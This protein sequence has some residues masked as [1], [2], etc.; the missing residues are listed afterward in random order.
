MVMKQGGPGMAAAAGLQA[1]HHIEAS[2]C[3]TVLLWVPAPAPHSLPR[4]LLDCHL[5]P[6]VVFWGNIGDQQIYVTANYHT[7]LQ[8]CRTDSPLQYLNLQSNVHKTGSTCP[9]RYK[10]VQESQGAVVRLQRMQ[11][12]VSRLAFDRQRV[13]Q[14]SAAHTRAAAVQI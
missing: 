4:P 13:N 9:K 2:L 11:D 3:Y 10:S 7:V 1:C 12:R 14:N 5:P 6:C 8:Q